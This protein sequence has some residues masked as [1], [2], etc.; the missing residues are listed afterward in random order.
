MRL[1]DVD[2]LKAQLG[3]ADKCDNCSE[4]MKAY[5][6]AN[7]DFSLTCELICN[8]PTVEANHIADD[9]KK[10]DAVEVV[11]CG[12]CEEW[13]KTIGDEGF[14]LGRCEFLGRDLVMNKGF[15]AWGVR[16][17]DADT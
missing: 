2:E 6:H 16:K 1:I 9:G 15:C 12:E 7:P 17:D 8:T 14:S 10:V 11:R 13:T 5:C 3:I 4:K